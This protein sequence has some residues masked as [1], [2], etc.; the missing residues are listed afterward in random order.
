MLSPAKGPLI[1]FA[2]VKK[3]ETLMLGREGVPCTLMSEP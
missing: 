1:A 2:S 3:L